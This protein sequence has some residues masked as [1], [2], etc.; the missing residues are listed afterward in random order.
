MGPAY[1]ASAAA[2]SAASSALLGRGASS[3]RICAISACARRSAR[4][5]VLVLDFDQLRP[6][7]RLLA[8]PSRNPHRAHALP[9]NVGPPA[10]VPHQ[11]PRNAGKLRRLGQRN[12]ARC[13]Q[14]DHDPAS[15][16]VLWHLPNG[17][18]HFRRSTNAPP[19][20]ISR[21][22]PR[23]SDIATVRCSPATTRRILLA[24]PAL[25]A[26]DPSTKRSATSAERGSSSKRAKS[27]RRSKQQAQR[28]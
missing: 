22:S 28:R 16:S 19:S 24:R 4:I 13:H 17:K 11:V 18:Q 27:E 6:I 26:P 21:K 15:L 23:H 1:A 8:P 2:A 20:A 10:P 5:C 12:Q 9:V 25:R 14:R 3:A 7:S